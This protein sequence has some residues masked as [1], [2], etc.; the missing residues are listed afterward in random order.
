M[1]IQPNDKLTI[2]I[3]KVKTDLNSSVKAIEDLERHYQN[4]RP[5]LNIEEKLSSLTT[6]KQRL[7]EIN[8]NLTYDRD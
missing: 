8:E 5:S 4:Y 1:H 3:L 6:L 2:T 7:M